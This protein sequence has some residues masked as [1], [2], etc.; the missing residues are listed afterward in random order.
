[1]VQFLKKHI[2]K[3]LLIGVFCFLAYKG[4]R[5]WDK[6]ADGF[7]IQ[8]IT[9]VLSTDPKWNIVYSAEDLNRVNRILDQPFHYLGRGFQCYAFVSQD[10]AYVLK[11]F[12]HQRL[13]VPEYLDW[14]PQIDY[15]KSLKENKIKELERRKNNLFRSFKIAYEAVPSETGIIYVHINKTSG[16]HEVVTVFDGSGNKHQIALDSMEFVVQRKAELLKPTIDHLMKQGKEDEAKQRISQIFD[17]LASCAKKGVL[18]TDGALIRKN[19]LGFLDDRA[20]Y[21]DAGKLALKD[22]IKKKEA[23]ESDT[24]RRLRPFAKWLEQTW[25]KLSLYYDKQQ[26]KAIKEF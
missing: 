1:M 6:R 7:T 16:L 20:I 9:S 13:R 19:N 22:R 5:A 10:G 11:F 4:A 23:F 12:R 21:I 24:K 15:V 18:D 2:F 17:L 26:D 3:I 25:P 8:K 14:L